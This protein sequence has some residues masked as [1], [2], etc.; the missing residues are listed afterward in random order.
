MHRNASK[1]RR[2][3]GPAG[4]HRRG[5]LTRFA[6]VLLAVVPL[7]VA[8]CAASQ[9]VLAQFPVGAGGQIQQIPPAP[10]LERSPPVLPIPRQAAPVAPAAPGP[11]FV[12]KSLR[13]TGE[14]RFSE[15]ELVTVTGF[16]LGSVST[17]SDLRAMAAK[18]TNY[19]N[20]RGY[21]VAQA[22][23]PPQDITDGT[24]T[25][26]V[27][28]G[29]YGQISLLNQTKVADVVFVRVL[30]GLKSGDL[31]N[32]APLERRLLIISDIPGVEVS[33]TLAP[34]TAVG[35][36]DLT[37]RVT[38]GPRFTGDVEAD[39]WGNPYTGAY[40][41]GGTVNLNEPFGIGDVL[42]VRI[43]GST[44]GGMGYG[45]ASYQAQVQDWTLGVAFTEFYYHLGKQFSALDAH[46]TEEIASVYASYPLI[47]SYNNNLNILF[48]FDERF[49]Q[50]DI[51]ATSTDDDK[52]ASV[53]IAGVSGDHTDTFGGGGWSTYS[54]IGSFGVLDIETP[55]ARAE[56]AATARTNGEYAKLWASV[57]RVQHLIGPLSLFGWIRGQ[58][59]SKNLDISEKMELGGASGV[60][61]FPEG[62]AYGDQG[63]IATLEARLLLPPL[64]PRLPGRVQLIAFV[65]TG[66]VTV[67]HTPFVGSTGYGTGNYYSPF[68]GSGPNGL[69]RSGAGGGI[70]WSAPNNFL[71]TVTY[72]YPIGSK[73]TSYPD[74][75]GQLWVQ[76]VKFF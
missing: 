55:A 19:Y 49:F 61:A 66:Y 70:I 63:Y 32:V 57:S 74:N 65:D 8:L 14:T 52:R 20:E 30:D 13:V 44:T 73:A 68:G 37:V 28:E 47:R 31:V 12:V 27:I 9:N 48:D 6:V 34:G 71:V 60:R 22:Y 2:R 25:I 46:G 24:V 45:R 26:A 23:L 51:G 38:P 29:R 16:K 64:P 56:D 50:D 21:F 39:N 40:L 11:S 62:E 15:A 69:T 54:L 59:A 4:H 1:I 3:T 18:I 76:F 17:L 33:S 58:A 10:V 5:A 41:L 36:S 53:L 67:N 72:A 35:T 7:V 75:S 42:S 43:L